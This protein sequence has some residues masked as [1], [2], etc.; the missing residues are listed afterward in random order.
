MSDQGSLSSRSTVAR[1]TGV[2]QSGSNRF[3]RIFGGPATVEATGRFL[4][5]H[6]WA[7]PVIAAIMLGVVGWLVNHIV[8]N[9]LRQRRSDE[10]TTLLNADIA[11][12]NAWMA[13]QRSTAELMA[14]DER[15]GA[16]V[17]DLLGIAG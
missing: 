4:R 10:L 8:E 3:L 1:P 2:S 15:L 9:A 5:R 17:Q 12:L 7:C 11:A 6:L 13:D 16:S 14:F